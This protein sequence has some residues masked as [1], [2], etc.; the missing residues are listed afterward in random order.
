M[1]LLLCNFW[2][3]VTTEEYHNLQIMFAHIRIQM[4]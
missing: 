2:L 3:D 1:K 4:Y